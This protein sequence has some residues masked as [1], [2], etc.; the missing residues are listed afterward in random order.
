[1]HLLTA[2]FLPRLASR[3]LAGALFAALALYSAASASPAQ[4]PVPIGSRLELFVD[5]YLVERM[6]QVEFQ[7]HHPIK[8]PRPKSPL[9][10]AHMVTVIKDG[11]RYRA[12]YRGRDQAYTGEKY[13]GD[14]GETV[15]Y[16]ESR[17]G[18]EWEF[19]L[20]RIH[21]V[22]GTY[23]NNVVLA[24]LPPFTTNFI[25]FLDTRPSVDPAER[26]KAVAGYPGTPS[27]RQPGAPTPGLF[28]FVSQ[29]GIHWTKKN[30][31]I[32]FRP[33]WRHAFDSSNSAFWSEAEQRYVCYFRTWS[34]KGKVRSV[35]RATSPDFVTWTE[36]VE[37]NPNLPGE[38]LY[39]TQAHPYVRA[40][41]L[42]IALP[43]RFVLGRGTA[44][45]SSPK[46]PNVTDILFMSTRAGSTQYDRTFTESFIRPGLDPARWINRAN[47]SALNVILTAPEELS[48]Y[49][50]SGDRYVLRTDGFISIHTG[51][52]EGELLT[53]P[54]VFEGRELVV[55][56]STGAAGDLRVELIDPE[57]R[58]FPGF[59]LED[60][61]VQFGDSIE[62][63]VRWKGG[64]PTALA[65]KALRLRFVMKECDLYSFRFR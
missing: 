45:E 34:A 59:S 53:K 65:G 60:C 3:L 64:D 51:A 8:A 18:H 49:H 63:I 31:I 4:P 42:Y 41:H 46:D 38:Q 32:P 10:E 62:R 43:T 23:E 12:W 2:N 5:G 36:P 44:G 33:E 58:P 17:D 7:L 47:Y 37:L 54:L 15:H 11:D 57:G 56:F 22:N 19:P 35:S 48:I 29:D 13:T 61:P 27:R 6:D 1:M 39:T 50:R 21:Q 9:P 30:E 28:G 14:P 52:K 55:N 26:Y 24:Q 25:P 16:A 40:P 20:L